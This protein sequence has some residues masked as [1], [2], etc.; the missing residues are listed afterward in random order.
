MH[1]YNNYCALATTQDIYISAPL[2]WKSTS[3]LPSSLRVMRVVYFIHSAY[4][5]GYLQYIG[6]LPIRSLRLG[7]IIENNGERKGARGGMERDLGQRVLRCVAQESG[8]KQAITSVSL[9]AA[10]MVGKEE[11]SLSGYVMGA[12]LCWARSDCTIIFARRGFS[13]PRRGFRHSARSVGCNGHIVECISL[14][15]RYKASM[16]K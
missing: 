2:S 10:P 5:A 4:P 15:S 12:A 8:R 7:V 1:R 16:S 3:R 11:A 14:S 6:I 13:K 9:D